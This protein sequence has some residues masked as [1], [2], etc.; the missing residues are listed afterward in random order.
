MRFYMGQGEVLNRSGL[1]LVGT[2]L[3]Q[4]TIRVSMCSRLVILVGVVIGLTACSTKE[5]PQTFQGI[6]GRYVLKGPGAHQ[7]CSDIPPG[8]DRDVC[9]ASNLSWTL[10]IADASLQVRDLNNRPVRNVITDDKGEFRV[11]ISEGEYLICA[12]FCEGP[13]SV[14]AGEFTYYELALAVP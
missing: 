12:D 1:R 11:E 10:P 7:D 14:K 4:I 9:D 13:I 2:I 3:D 6:E 5:A 8:E